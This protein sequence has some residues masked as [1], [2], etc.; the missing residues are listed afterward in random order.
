M[1]TQEDRSYSPWA[2]SPW[3]YSPWELSYEDREQPA[4]RLF[5][6]LAESHLKEFYALNATVRESEEIEALHKYRVVM[7]RTRSLFAAGESV[8]PAPE[9]SELVDRIGRLS[10]LTSPLRDLDVLLVDLDQHAQVVTGR[11]RGGLLGLRAELERT[12]FAAREHLIE[13]LDGDAFAEL[14]AEWQAL[15]SVY[16]LGGSE[17]GS[18]ALR[19]AGVVVD[20]VIGRSFRRLRKQGR[21][22]RSSDTDA[23]WHRLRKRLKRFRYLLMAFESLYPIGTF[24]KVLQ[25]LAHLQ[26]SLGKLQD[27]VA[28]ADLVE[29]AGLSKGGQTALFAGALV[30]HLSAER[31]VARRACESAWERFDRPKVRRNLGE[32]LAART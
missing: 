31:P 10:D 11:L 9:L 32:V 4:G 3:A 22:A 29:T 2:Y 5:A 6:L 20:E 21:R 15:A 17:P 13:S 26:D 16:R 7:R 24:T 25:Q 18:D 30:D 27:Y 12:R 14:L 23:E 1:T 19:P 8:F 28:I